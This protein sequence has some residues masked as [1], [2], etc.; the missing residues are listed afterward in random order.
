MLTIEDYIVS[1]KKKDKLDEFD[2]QRHSENM[3]KVIQYVSDY[4]N[5]YLNLEDYSYE[6]VKT[7]QVIDK[8]KE[9]IIENFPTT[10]EFIISY[11]WSNKK[12]I[13]KLLSKAYEE[14][15]D[16]EV[17]YLLE[18]DIKVAEYVCKKKLG[19]ATTE[20]ILHNIA[21]MSKE[22][23]QTQTE[24][25]NMSDMKELDNAIS[26]WVIDVFR[27]YKVNLLDYARGISYKYY[28][29]YVDSEYNRQTETFYYIN[30]YD[31]RYQDNPFNINDIYNRNRHRE[32]IDGHKGELEMLIMYFWL[33][34]DVHDQDYWPE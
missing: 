33:F 18:D 20:E 29:R 12:R 11:Y 4:F 34:E 9:G 31:Y 26:D 23:R 22:Y 5:Q 24:E 2:F 10:Y 17:F 16:I 7:Q 25:P 3:G 1:R 21:T 27:K 8:F 30:K 15:E 32:F 14:I 13:D 28:E 19:V 6:Q